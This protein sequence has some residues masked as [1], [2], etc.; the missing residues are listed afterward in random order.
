MKKGKIIVIE[1]SCDGVGKSTQYNMLYEHLIK[2]GLSVF[3]HK[4]PSYNTNQGKLVEMY[5]NGEF[6]DVK[7]LSPYFVNSLFALLYEKFKFVG[8][9]FYKAI[10]FKIVFVAFKPN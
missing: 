3:C 10:L 7:D 1:G 9:Y 2:D 8:N 4:F 5:L 6:G